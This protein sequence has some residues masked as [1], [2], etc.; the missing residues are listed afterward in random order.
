[1][2]RKIR[3]LW[4]GMLGILLIIAFVKFLLPVRTP[5]AIEQ[6]QANREIVVY[7]TGAVRH[8]GLLNLPLDARLDDALA[9]AVL[10][11]DADLEALNPA[12]KL[13]DGQ[14]IIVPYQALPAESGELQGNPAALPKQN[15][16]VSSGKSQA[17]NSSKVNINYAGI[18]ELDAIP[19]I[20]PAL[21]Q[22]IIDYRMQNGLFSSPEEIQNVSGIGPK[23]YEKMAAYITVGP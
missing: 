7:V 9:K 15:I 11:E 2:D 19:G 12:Q 16:G 4:W 8:P 13:K 23:T 10:R 14:K 3:F 6:T 5:Q 1:M 22:R 17:S 20:G 18:T 21:A